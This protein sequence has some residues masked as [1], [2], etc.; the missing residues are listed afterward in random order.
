MVYNSLQNIGQPIERE[1]AT[2]ISTA[3]KKAALRAHARR[4][5]L[6]RYGIELTR[7]KQNAIVRAIQKGQGLFLRRQSLRV[8]EWNVAFEGKE[9]RVIYD[10]KRKTLITCLPPREEKGALE[11]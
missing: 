10:G 11:P 3:T 6:E 1:G 9:L 4:R 7:E 2:P 5:A 8:T